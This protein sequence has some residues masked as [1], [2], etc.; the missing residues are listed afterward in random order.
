MYFA[1]FCGQVSKKN[2]RCRLETHREDANTLQSSDV[3]VQVLYVRV[4]LVPCG[5]RS[6][7]DIL[8]RIV[9][10]VSAV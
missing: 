7:E 8:C 1:H 10:E 3:L 5:N 4:D 9:L 2:P 6:L